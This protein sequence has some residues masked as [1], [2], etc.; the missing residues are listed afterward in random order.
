MSIC[1]RVVF[2]SKGVGGTTGNIRL[3]TSA[4]GVCVSSGIWKYTFRSTSLF[5]FGVFSTW[6]DCSLL[7]F[8]CSSVLTTP[9]SLL[10][11][12]CSISSDNSTISFCSTTNLSAT[13]SSLILTLCSACLYSDFVRIFWIA[14][15][16]LPNSSPATL[17]TFLI[18]FPFNSLVVSARYSS[19]ISVHL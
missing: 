5:L 7:P 18:F 12:L 14:P 16:V 3:L 1:V 8:D 19:S 10:F 6:I 11:S 13:L 9:I 2:S 4:L 17:F 15:S